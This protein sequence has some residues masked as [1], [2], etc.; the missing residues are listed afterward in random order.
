MTN[1]IYRFTRQRYRIKF[2]VI[3]LNTLSYYSCPTGTSV[4]G[5]VHETSR[6]VFIFELDDIARLRK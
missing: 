5:R 6:V 3:S 1:L 2:Y 4:E